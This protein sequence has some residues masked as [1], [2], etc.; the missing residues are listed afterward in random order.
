MS[1]NDLQ[2]VAMRITTQTLFSS[3]SEKKCSISY[4]KN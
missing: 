2:W 4:D 3:T 1:Y